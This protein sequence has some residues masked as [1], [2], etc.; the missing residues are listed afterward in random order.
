MKNIK[1]S[2][3]VPSWHYYIDP[4]KHQPYWELYYATHV[5]KNFKNVNILDMRVMKEKTLEDTVQNIEY[6]NFYF[7]WIFKTGDAKE[8]Y[9]VVSLLKKKYPDS[10]HAAGGTHVDMCSDECMEIFDSIV[11]GSGEE[12]F[13]QIIDDKL[14][15]N[16]SKVYFKN[17]KDKPF[18]E[19]EFPDRS[20]LPKESVINNQMFKQYGNYDATMVYFSRGCFYKCAYIAPNNAHCH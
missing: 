5:K 10:I 19:T 12:S 7:Y 6:S 18:A 17:Y 15:N 3:I 13:S 14:N 2:F 1:I 16:L 8:I 4:G 11:L 9:S 20:F